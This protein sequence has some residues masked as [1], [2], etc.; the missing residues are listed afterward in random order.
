MDHWDAELRTPFGVESSTGDASCPRRHV[1]ALHLDLASGRGRDGKLQRVEV[2]G[3]TPVTICEVAVGRGG[4]WGSDG[5]IVF[6]TLGSGLFQVSASGGAA[7]PLTIPDISRGE[8]S[9]RW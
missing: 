8:V 5:R 3:G 9:H 6:G 7:A 2:S 1:R 4:A